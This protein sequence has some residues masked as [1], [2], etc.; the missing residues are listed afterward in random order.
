[1]GEKYEEKKCQEKEEFKIIA[2]G[3]NL[4]YIT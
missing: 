1:M 2:L 4:I 3:E